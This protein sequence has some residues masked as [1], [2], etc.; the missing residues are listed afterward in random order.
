MNSIESLRADPALFL[1]IAFALNQIITHVLV[2]ACIGIT[3]LVVLVF[4]HVP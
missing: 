3:A 1:D 4:D 2:A